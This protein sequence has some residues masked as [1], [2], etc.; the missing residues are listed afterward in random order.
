MALQL[1]VVLSFTAPAPQMPRITPG[2][3]CYTLKQLALPS[4][5]SLW[6]P[7]PPS[8]IPLLSLACLKLAYGDPCCL[9][10]SIQHVFGV[11][12]HPI[13]CNKQD[14]GSCFSVLVTSE[15]A[16]EHAGFRPIG[17]VGRGGTDNSSHRAFQFHTSFAEVPWHC[18]KRRL[19]RT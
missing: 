5:A 15:K 7:Q 8:E 17:L 9:T 4:S 11:T 6:Q 2:M 13:G 10:Q 3:T 14:K 18:S 12:F 19:S 1:L 16:N